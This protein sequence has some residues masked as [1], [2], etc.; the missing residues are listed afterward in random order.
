MDLYFTKQIITGS[1]AWELEKNPWPVFE[2]G[3]YS[4]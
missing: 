3:I 1:F 2:V 4:I